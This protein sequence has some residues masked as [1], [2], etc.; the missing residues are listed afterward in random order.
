MFKHWIRIKCIE[1]LNEIACKPV[2]LDATQDVD[3]FMLLE[4]F[5]VVQL[6]KFALVLIRWITSTTIWPLS[7]YTDVLVYVC[8]P[9][10]I[11]CQ[12][13]IMFFV[14]F[15][16]ASLCSHLAEQSDFNAKNVRLNFWR[17]EIWWAKKL[18]S[19][20]LN[21]MSWSIIWTAPISM[22]RI[23]FMDISKWF[24][25]IFIFGN[26]SCVSNHEK[27]IKTKWWIVDNWFKSMKLSREWEIL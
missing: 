4:L 25:L 14:V 23:F 26:Q 13:P 20:S 11:K 24:R 18:S 2:E 5:A 19:K 21:L 22:K 8:I 27:P 3:G 9:Q 15:S 7:H 17:T 12:W 10:R 1:I 16:D 6:M